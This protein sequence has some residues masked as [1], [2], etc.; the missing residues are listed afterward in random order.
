MNRRRALLCSGLLLLV[1]AMTVCFFSARRHAAGL[2]APGGP[3]SSGPAKAPPVVDLNRHD[4]QTIDFSS[5]RPV[6][7]DTPAD[8]AALDQAVKE[9]EEAAKDVTFAPPPQTTD[10]K[11]V[12]PP[13]KP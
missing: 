4:G 8:K 3:R 12:A 13:Q 7:K 9:M 2:S 6:A 1:L 10:Q 5:G 11:A